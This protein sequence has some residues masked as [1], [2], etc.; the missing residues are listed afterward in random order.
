MATPTAISLPELVPG[1]HWQFAAGWPYLTCELLRD[2]PHGFFTRHFLGLP[3]AKLTTYLN[4]IAE[5]YR[6]QQ[7]H[8][9]AVLTP[10]EIRT[11]QQSGKL[12]SEWPLADGLLTETVEQ[13][14]WVASADCTPVLI[15]DRGTG[16]VAALHAGWRGTAQRIVPM[17]IARL[18]N[19]G[20]QLTDLAVALGP[21]IAG[22]VYQVS[23]TVAAE[24]GASIVP[25]ER[26]TE[27][28]AI[29]AELQAQ[30]HPPLLPDPKPGH[31]RLD[32]RRI[33]TIQLKQLGLSHAQITQA[34]CCTYQ[35][36]DL[37]FSYRRTHEKQVQ[38]S[39]ISSN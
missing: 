9:H 14:V 18:L 33:N 31:L 24:V 3:P 11:Q 32:V 19:S 20:S 35:Q 4:A 7:V 6:V 13:A 15:A 26:V 37:F 21:A 29:C 22:E 12:T 28:A 34:P 10:S 25:T 16:R 30:H 8:G 27:P 38:W 2:W 23:T 36:P 5:P 17:A 39:G 1:W